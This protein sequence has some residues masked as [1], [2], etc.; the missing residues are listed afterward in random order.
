[1]TEAERCEKGELQDT[2][3]PEKFWVD[4]YQEIK[5]KVHRHEG[6]GDMGGKPKQALKEKSDKGGKEQ[7]DCI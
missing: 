5:G 1:M 4:A 3:E 2:E 7:V 6:K